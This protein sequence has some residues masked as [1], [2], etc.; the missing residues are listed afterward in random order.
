MRGVPKTLHLD[1]AAEF[2]SRA[3]RMG[4]AQYGIELMY[5]PVGRPQFGGHIER[6]NRTL[7]QRVKGLPG[8]VGNSTVGPIVEHKARESANRALLSLNEFERWLALEVAQ[9][10]HHSAHSGVMGGTPASAWATLAQACP[11][12]LLPPGP[13]EA[14]RFLVR[15]LPVA[16]RTIQAD[17][18]TL[19]HIRYWHPIFVAWRV[20]NRSVVVRYHPEDLSRIFVS[21]DG[22][23]HLEALS[24]K[25]NRRMCVVRLFRYGSSGLFVGS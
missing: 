9:R 7:M 8:A 16:A 23:D 19:F 3:P 12:R 24:F 5:R 10:Y 1:N 13:D 17:G 14:L 15:F 21:K 6:M 11:A 4:C 18:L 20:A 22:K 25:P 2:K